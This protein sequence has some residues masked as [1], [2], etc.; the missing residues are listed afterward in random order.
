MSARDMLQDIVNAHRRVLAPNVGAEFWR[1]AR[2]RDILRSLERATPQASHEL[3][4]SLPNDVRA[5][6][7]C[8]VAEEHDCTFEGAVKWLCE[9]TLTK[10]A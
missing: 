10:L 8:Y 2:P 9:L 7:A 6:L 5:S 4:A 1:D 3:Y